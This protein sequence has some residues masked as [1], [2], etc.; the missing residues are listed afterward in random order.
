MRK[1]AVTLSHSTHYFIGIPVQSD[2]QKWLEEWQEKLKPYVSYKVWTH[3]EDFHITLKFLGNVHDD[4][5]TPLTRSLDRTN[6]FSTFVLKIGLLGFF[7][8]KTQPRVMWAGVEKHTSLMALQTKV[9]KLC[10]RHLFP[11]EKRP[12]TPHITLAKKW[13]TAKI[14]IPTMDLQPLLP[15]P[16]TRIMEVDR[17]CL[18]RIHPEN[19]VK[20]ESVY[21]KH[22][23]NK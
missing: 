12:Y 7:G 20:Y 18:Y 16:Q 14:S 6:E 4:Q 10:Q 13:K 1:G 9:D 15:V 22:L 2:I 21:I 11:A 23:S 3:P 19:E 17:F 8:N 5:V